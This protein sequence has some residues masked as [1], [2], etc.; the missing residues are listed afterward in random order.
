MDSKRWFILGAL[1][2]ARTAMG[3]Q[4]QSVV[5]VSSF[6]RADLGIGLGD[7]GVLVGAF[8]LPGILGSLPGGTLGVRIGESE[9]PLPVFC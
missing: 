3:F 9:S 7:L 1:F 6:L 2:L 8:M 4:F 5:G